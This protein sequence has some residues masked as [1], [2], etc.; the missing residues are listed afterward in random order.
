MIALRASAGATDVRL[1]RKLCYDYAKLKAKGKV[2]NSTSALRY[3]GTR[4]CFGYFRSHK[5]NVGVQT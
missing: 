3:Q 5:L 2:T 4:E 1:E